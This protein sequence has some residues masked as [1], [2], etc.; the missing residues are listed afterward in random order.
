M[1]IANRLRGVIEKCIDGVQS[2]F[3]PGHLISDNVLL[4]YELLHMLKHKRLG[5]KGFMAVK[6]DMSKAY[7]KVEWNFIKEIML[8][9]GFDQKWVDDLMKCVTTVSYSV[10][11]NGHIGEKFLPTKGLR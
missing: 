7:D 11:I 8:R 4:A 3:V 6:L 2:A 10:V 9:M 5:K 1:V